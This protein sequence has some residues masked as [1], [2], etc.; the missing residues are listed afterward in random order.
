MPFSE[1]TRDLQEELRGF[2]ICVC[3]ESASGLEI[4]G[5]F[6]VLGDQKSML[7]VHFSLENSVIKLICEK[8][9]N[10][11]LSSTFSGNNSNCYR[12]K[13]ASTSQLS[14]AALLCREPQQ[15]LRVSAGG[16][17]VKAEQSDCALLTSVPRK[18]LEDL[19]VL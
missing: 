15:P 8:H 2:K 14:V 1:F 7:T 12:T 3:I 5:Y 13:K 17:R 16:P 9:E 18:P 4:V 19:Q 10:F 6:Q 11:Q